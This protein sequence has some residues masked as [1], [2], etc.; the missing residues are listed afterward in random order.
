ML[1]LNNIIFLIVLEIIELFI[2]LKVIKFGKGFI[3]RRLSK[4]A[5][6]TLKLLD[7]KGVENEKVRFIDLWRF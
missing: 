6:I 3:K 4:K 1:I 7:F 5:I 2:I